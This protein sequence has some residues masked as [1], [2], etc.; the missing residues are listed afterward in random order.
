MK[1]TE[2]MCI[3]EEDWPKP[4]VSLLWDVSL[5]LGGAEGLF[6]TQMSSFL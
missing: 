3:K 2:E 1:A 6:T 4:Q 5:S